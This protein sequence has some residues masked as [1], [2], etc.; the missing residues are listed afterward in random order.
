MVENSYAMLRQLYS[1]KDSSRSYELKDLSLDDQTLGELTSKGLA[2]I[3]GER[4]VLTHLGFNVAHYIGET[5]RSLFRRA[6]SRFAHVELTGAN[7]DDIACV[8]RLLKGADK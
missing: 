5:K 6:E 8:K 3:D 7:D 1:S 4:L 2:R